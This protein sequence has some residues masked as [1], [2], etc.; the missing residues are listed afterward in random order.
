MRFSKTGFPKTCFS[1]TGFSKKLVFEN[2][3]SQKRLFE[4]R[5]FQNRFFKNNW[6]FQNCFSK[7]S[8]TRAAEVHQHNLRR[9]RRAQKH[10]LQLQVPMQNLVLDNVVVNGGGDKPWG[11]NYYCPD[12]G[13]LHGTAVGGTLPVPGCFK[14]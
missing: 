14:K 13:V 5:F 10:V 7:L 9:V 11:H 8:E 3:F 6:L 4:N 2:R 12:G 1:K